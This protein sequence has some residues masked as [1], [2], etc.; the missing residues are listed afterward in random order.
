MHEYRF[1]LYT[2]GKQDLDIKNSHLIS[3]NNK[4][5][6]QQRTLTN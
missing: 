4:L 3:L 2:V 6:L 1:L 5:R